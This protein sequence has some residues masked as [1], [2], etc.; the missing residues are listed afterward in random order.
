MNLIIILACLLGERF[1]WEQ[2]SLRRSGWFTEYSLWYQ[3]QE[4][5][6]WMNEGFWGV[7][8]LLL[9]PL[10]AVALLQALLDGVLWGIPSVLFA[11]LVLFFSLGPTDL[12]RQVSEYAAARESGDEETSLATARH[13]LDDE[14]PPSEPTCSQAV[15]ESILDQANSHIFAVIFWFLL[16]GPMGALLYRMANHLRKPPQTTQESDLFHT[17]NRLVDIL[18]WIPARLTAFSYAI[19]GSFEDALIGWR[20]YHESRFNEFYSSASGILVCTGSGAMRLATL[21]ETQAEESPADAFFLAK[22]AMGLVWR[23]LVVWIIVLGF[24]TLA[25]WL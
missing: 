18:N 25:D 23:S 19:A 8:L 20:S 2:Q 11:C 13:L 9:L 16:L 24:L 14:P 21:L 3:R 12:D 6:R 17:A 15:A 5:P 10:L 4:L 7:I 1:F 22:A